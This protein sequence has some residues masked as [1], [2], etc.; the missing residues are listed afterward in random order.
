MFS[1]TLASGPEP[2]IH[3]PFYLSYSAKSDVTET[4]GKSCHSKFEFSEGVIL[5]HWF[6]I[7]LTC[8]VRLFFFFFPR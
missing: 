7:M 2:G 4:A 5:F 1:S 3:L 8:L 6:L